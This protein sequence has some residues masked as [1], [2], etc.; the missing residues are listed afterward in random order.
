[1][2]SCQILKNIQLNSNDA[3]Y[4]VS[5]KHFPACYIF[6]NAHSTILH[7]QFVQ[8]LKCFTLHYSANL[9][10]LTILNQGLIFILVILRAKHCPFVAL[11]F[12]LNLLQSIFLSILLIV[13]R[14]WFSQKTPHLMYQNP[15]LIS[16]AP[17]VKNTHYNQYSLNYVWHSNSHTT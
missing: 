13:I 10:L 9:I 1:M 17:S 6:L 14:F 2:G 11:V 7:V 12:K 16:P 3:D 8:H 5:T 4:I 15:Q